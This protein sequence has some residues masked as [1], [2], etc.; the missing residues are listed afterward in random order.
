MRAQIAYVG[1]R[2]LGLLRE[3][4][5]NFLLPFGPLGGPVT[6]FKDPNF[7]LI[8]VNEGS[9]QSVY[10]GL[11]LS[12]ERRLSRGLGLMANYTWSHSIDNAS[13]LGSF[14]TSILA[15]RSTSP[16]PSNPNDLRA[17]RGNSNFDVRHVFTLSYNWELP[18]KRWRKSPAFL[19]AG[20]ELSSIVTARTGQPFTVAVGMD[21][22]GIGDAT[23][24]FSQRP[25][26][27]PG[28]PLT[29]SQ[30]QGP[31]LPLNP[32]AFS[33]PEFGTFGNLGRNAFRGPSFSQWD[34]TLSKTIR[35]SERFKV[36]LR[37][38]AFN[39]FNRPNFALPTETA[40]LSVAQKSPENFGTSTSTIN[41]QN[42]NVGPVFAPGGPRSMQI[43]IKILETGR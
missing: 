40:N 4:I 5:I 18:L 12:L 11:Q 36:Q 32:A 27:V 25:N 39:L 38:E 9:A 13:T 10:H 7:G 6:S 17:E 28:V 16:F 33:V 37:L 3:R 21:A 22:A 29:L 34:F 35:V 20:W 24:F 31:R 2:S 15:A 19:V 43:G 42:L 8:E 41:T 14:G 30:R 23:P 26:R 1:S